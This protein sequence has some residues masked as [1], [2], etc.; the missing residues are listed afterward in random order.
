M[1][2]SHTIEGARRGRAARLARFAGGRERPASLRRWRGEASSAGLPGAG[3]RGM[4]MQFRCS[5]AGRAVGVLEV[6]NLSMAAEQEERR[7]ACR[8]CACRR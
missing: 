7:V 5:C 2:G 8:R 3:G 4:T 6:S 1:S